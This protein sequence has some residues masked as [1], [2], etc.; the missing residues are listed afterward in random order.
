MGSLVSVQFLARVGKPWPRP[1]L[2]CERHLETGEVLQRF[3]GFAIE[4][5]PEAD[6]PAVQCHRVALACGLGAGVSLR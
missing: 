5:A 1:P 3:S 4:L 2:D 6:T